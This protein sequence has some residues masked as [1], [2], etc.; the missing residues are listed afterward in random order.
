MNMPT[1]KQRD[2]RYQIL[3]AIADGWEIESYRCDTKQWG[4]PHSIL[5]SQICVAYRVVPNEFRVV[6]DENGWL[7]WYQGATQASPD[8]NVLV[9]YILNVGSPVIH[10]AHAK[11]LKWDDDC[12][13][14]ITHYRPHYRPHK[15]RVLVKTVRHFD[16]GTSEEA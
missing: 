11:W 10:T 7:P 13:S 9:D 15:E 12:G 16:D 1:V 3:R 8:I 6:P 14:V 2:D 5:V 4:V